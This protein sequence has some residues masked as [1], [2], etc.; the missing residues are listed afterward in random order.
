MINN[1]KILL[2]IN[3]DSFLKIKKIKK[4]KSNNN[5]LDNEIVV[6]LKM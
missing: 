3:F 6:Q 4:D 1:F 5:K 2:S